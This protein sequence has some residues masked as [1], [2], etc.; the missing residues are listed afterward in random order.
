MN[1]LGYVLTVDPAKLK[2]TDDFGS[3]VNGSAFLFSRVI[4]LI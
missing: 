1:L 2:T 4:H 3:G